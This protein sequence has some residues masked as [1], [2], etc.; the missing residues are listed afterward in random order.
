MKLVIFG[1]TGQTGHYLLKNALAQGHHVSVFVRDPQKLA[2][3]LPKEQI[4]RGD[5]QDSEA[6][7]R[8]TRGNEAVLFVIGSEG[9]GP[10]TLRQDAMRS[11]IQAMQKQ[12]VKRIVALST[13][14]VGNAG[15]VANRILRPLIFR[16]TVADSQAMEILIRAS[17]LDFTIVRAP[18]LRQEEMDHA[19]KEVLGDGARPLGI[20]VSRGSVA[21]VMLKSLQASRYVRQIV[22]ISD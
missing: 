20:S 3:P 8:A 16:N 10:T 4:H 6:I 19:Y 17:S 22:T 15:F 7:E 5:V 14:M 9:L 18:R 2:V 13:A 1:A 12:Q 21:H 11:I